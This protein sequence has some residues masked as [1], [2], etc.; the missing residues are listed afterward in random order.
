[1]STNDVN[2][3]RWT[4]CGAEK[5]GNTFHT[6][7]IISVQSVNASVNIAAAYMARENYRKAGEE[8][9]KVVETYGGNPRFVPQVDFSRQQLEALE[10]ARVL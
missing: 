5:T 10:E 3:V 9:Q 1:M 8:F 2:A 7:L 6:A 4:G